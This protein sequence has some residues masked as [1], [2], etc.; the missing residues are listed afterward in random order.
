ME[1]EGEKG[2]GGGGDLKIGKGLARRALEKEF[3]RNRSTSLE[4]ERINRI[5]LL[6]GAEQTV[7]RDRFKAR[8]RLR[9]CEPKGER[10]KEKK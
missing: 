10:N 3:R 2:V 6:E 5:N 8:G 9:N 4:V 7:E 1:R